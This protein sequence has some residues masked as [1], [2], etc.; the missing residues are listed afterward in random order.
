MDG[1]LTPCF[2]FLLFPITVMMKEPSG[3]D[4]L[5]ARK[6]KKEKIK[7]QQL[8][9]KISLSSFSFFFF[10]YLLPFECTTETLRSI[11]K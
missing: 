1:R 2:A 11:M 10:F 7:K 6:K 9:T 8:A 4:R 5:R 3:C